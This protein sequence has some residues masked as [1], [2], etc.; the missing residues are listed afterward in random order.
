MKRVKEQKI[1]IMAVGSE[2]LTPYF[3]DTDSLYL[4]RRL[5]ELGMA[6]T[7]KSIVGDEWESLVRCIKVALSRADFII[8]V[9][10]LGPTQDD[11]TR[12][13][14]AFVL[15]RKLIYKHELLEKIKSRFKKRNLSMP[16]MNKK[17][18]Y[19]IEGSEILENRYGTAPGL[20][21]AFGSKIVI[22]LPGP[23]HEMITMF[24]SYVWPR[25]INY[26]KGFTSRRILKITGLTESK[27]DALLV[28]LHPK[29]P[30]LRLTTLAYPGQ[31][32]IHLTSHSGRSLS[33]AEVKIQRLETKILER[34]GK[35]VFSCSGE[36]IEEV[37][38]KLLTKNRKTLAV[39]ESCTGGL[40]G[41]RLTNVSGSSNYFVLGAVA[42]SNESK[43]LLLGV[44]PELI[45][46]HGSVSPEVAQAMAENVREKSASDYG[47]GITGI[48]GPEGGTE[49][50]PVGL[51]YVALAWKKGVTV[52]KNLFLGNRETIKFQSSQK[53]LD[54]LRRHLIKN[55][56]RTDISK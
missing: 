47:V 54:M 51:V 56:K 27:T 49:E 17:Q 36:E 34:L 46:N 22:L 8:A 10:G 55:E 37:V 53:A 35:H 9:G 50:K 45:Q 19:I 12:E 44:R 16:S 25:L 33:C 3:Q 31:I 5:N 38:G 24:E 7:Y 1:E 11:R 15:G 2:L 6:V 40:L 28:D 21:L 42:Y 43:A 41:H 14:Y 4:T 48:A 18:A 30:S 52:T 39:A 20:W 13:A 32:E 23:P 29:T 26:H